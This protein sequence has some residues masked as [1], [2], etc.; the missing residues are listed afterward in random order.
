MPVTHELSVRAEL[1]EDGGPELW[2]EFM[3]ELRVLHLGGVPK[4]GRRSVMERLQEAFLAAV[5]R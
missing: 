1:L 2:D 3:D 5:G 4:P